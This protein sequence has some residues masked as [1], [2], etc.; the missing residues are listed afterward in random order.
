MT[1]EDLVEIEALKRL[2]YR[3]A[4]LID[5]KDWDGLAECFTPDATASYGGGNQRLEGRDAI[6]RFLRGNLESTTMITSHTVGQPEIELTGPETA[7]ATWALQDLVIDTS[8]G[9]T[10]RGASFYTDEYA[11][12]DGE[13]KLTHTSYKRVY[14]ELARRPDNVRVTASW[15]GTGGKSELMPD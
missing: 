2:K 6:L 13:W 3:Y 7:K 8:R 10:V 1:P 14:E 4:R 15:H 5:Q 9:F 12:A 11:K